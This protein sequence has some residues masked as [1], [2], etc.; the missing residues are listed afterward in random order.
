MGILNPTTQNSKTFQIQTEHSGDVKSNQSKYKH[1]KYRLFED[2]I[3]NGSDFKGSGKSSSFSR[4]H[5]KNK[6]FKIQTFLS[7]FLMVIDKMAA[8]GSQFQIVGFQL[9]DF[10]SHLKSRSRPTKIWTCLDFRHP[11]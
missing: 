5:S 10:R 7:R 3:S 1:F 4:N 11:L 6:P 8:N 2:C 9:S